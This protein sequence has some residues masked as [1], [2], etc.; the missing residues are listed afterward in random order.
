MLSVLQTN[1]PLK[2]LLKTAEVSR[3]GTL[4][5]T[6]EEMNGINGFLQQPKMEHKC[7]T[8]Q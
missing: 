4:R 5:E 3:P 7:S 8:D 6:S 1:W 2:L